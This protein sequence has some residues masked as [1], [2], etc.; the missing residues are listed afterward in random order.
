MLEWAYPPLSGHPGVLTPKIAV[1]RPELNSRSSVGR[2]DLLPLNFSLTLRT[3][4]TSFEVHQPRNRWFPTVVSTLDRMIVAPESASQAI[5]KGKE[6]SYIPTGVQRNVCKVSHHL[7]VPLCS[8]ECS[9]NTDIY[10]TYHGGG[11]DVRCMVWSLT[12][13]WYTFSVVS[14]C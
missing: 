7:K 3:F 14:I 11:L 10:T 9:D 1:G 2:P 5:L 12:I 4:S 13:L 6:C 8:Q